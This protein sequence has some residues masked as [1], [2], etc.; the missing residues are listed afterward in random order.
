MID[1]EKMSRDED[2]YVRAKVA[3]NPLCPDYI[4]IIHI[5]EN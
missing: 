3:K 4:R 2:W 1:F 5:L